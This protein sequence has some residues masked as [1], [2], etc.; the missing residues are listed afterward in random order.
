MNKIHDERQIYD[1]IYSQY[2]PT[3]T[4]CSVSC[5]DP[6]KAR[7]EVEGVMRVFG[8]PSLSGKRILDVGCGLGY[9]AQAFLEKGAKVIAIDTST[10]A[11]QLV[12]ERFPEVEARIASFPD[13]ITENEKFDI[14]WARGLSLINTF[15]VDFIYREFIQSCLVLLTDDGSLIIGWVSNFSETMGTSN[16]AHWSLNMINCLKA[17]AGL[18]GPRVVTV[19]TS[20]LSLS[21]IHL[22]RI[23][24]KSVPIYFCQHMKN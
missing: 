22:G 14:I 1:T 15:D 20:I 2:K 3:K 13:D 18:L 19:P 9:Y 10:V 8:I 11:I 7:S 23:L 5:Y 12:K 4:N 24:G 6:R 16:W 17:K 21:V